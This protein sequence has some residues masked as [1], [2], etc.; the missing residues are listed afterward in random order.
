VV[1]FPADH[2]VRRPER[3][4]EAVIR[5]MAVTDDQPSR[6]ALIGATAEGPATDLGWIMP[7]KGSPSAPMGEV[8][9]DRF[10][11]K[12]RAAEASGLMEQGG[13][14]N[15]M[16]LAA[17]LK[18]LWQVLAAHLPEQA[19]AIEHYALRMERP[20]AREVLAEAYRVMPA[21]DLSRAVLENVGGLSM[22]PMRNAG[23]SD[24][25]TPKRLLACIGGAEALRSLSARL[26]AGPPASTGSD[27]L[28]S[29]TS[30]EISGFRGPKARARVS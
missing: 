4:R 17:R 15:T 25:G 3:Y 26:H 22:V 14:W 29:A 23:W 7:A 11:E 30:V 27:C 20:D 24:C 9:V 2:H 5:A 8:A 19:M 10:I 6:L 18:S 28:P 21:A 1:I 16:I 13:F 12:P